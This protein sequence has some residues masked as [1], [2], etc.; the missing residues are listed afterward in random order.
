LQEH[1]YKQFMMTS[2]SISNFEEE[3]KKFMAIEVEIENM[4]PFYCIGALMLNATNLKLQL[5][6]ECRLWKMLYSNKVHQLA[7]EKTY[8]MFEYMR[9]TTNKLNIEVSSLDSLRFVMNVLKDIRERESNIEMEFIP[10]MDMYAMLERYLPGGV[11]DK[12]EVEQKTTMRSTWRKLIDFAD[13]VTTNL[14]SIQGIYKKQLIWD[15]R[16]FTID[17]RSLRKDFEENGPMQPG[18][19]PQAAVDKL[20]K[21]KARYHDTTSIVYKCTLLTSTVFIGRSCHS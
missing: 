13:T 6:N 20:K 3:L 17:I 8:D 4:A 18:I 7:K 11:V 2:P 19:K 14:G 16:D 15:I 1:A 9:I 10:I 21:F 12:D 5:R